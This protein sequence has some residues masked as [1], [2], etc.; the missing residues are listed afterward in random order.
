VALKHTGDANMAAWLVERH[1]IRSATEDLKAGKFSPT[2]AG[3]MR[4]YLNYAREHWV[5]PNENP[6]VGLILC[7]E[8]GAAE[9]HYAPDNLRNKVLA[10]EFQTILP[11]ERLIAGEL[12]RSR[13]ELERRRLSAG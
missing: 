7:A 13:E 3:Q 6:P 4:L 2:D 1:T 8:E 9:A 11:Y 5:K 10:T 12:E